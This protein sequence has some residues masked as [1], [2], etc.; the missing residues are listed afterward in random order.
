M[1][2]LDVR[3]IRRIGSL[4]SDAGVR[5]FGENFQSTFAF[6]TELESLLKKNFTITRAFIADNRH[7]YRDDQFFISDDG[8]F[9]DRYESFSLIFEKMSSIAELFQELC[10]VQ[11][12]TNLQKYNR[13]L[14]QIV[15]DD[16]LYFVKQVRY[17]ENVIN[18]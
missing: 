3:S 12:P 9:L 11:K 17:Q 6:L 4:D 16:M 2:K 1:A 15:I 10:A 18:S 14:T 13:R 8:F 7:V 5:I